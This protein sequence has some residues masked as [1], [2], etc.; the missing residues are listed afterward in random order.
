MSDIW[1]TANSATLPPQEFYGQIFTDAFY[2]ILQKGI[3]K[4]PFDADQHK[5]ERRLTCINI[6][7]QCFKRNGGTFELHREVIAEF[8]DWAGI[9]LPSLKICGIHPRDLDE[10][11]ARFEMAE[12]GRTWT[13]KTSGEERKATV[14]KFL[15][16]YPDEAA[17]RVA[18]EARYN[19]ATDE[20]EEEPLPMPEK[21]NGKGNG[22]EREVAARFL[23]ALVAQANGDVTKL[24]ELLAGNALTSRYFD[25]NSP[26][27]LELVVEA[28]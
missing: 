28:A 6:D 17:C 7:A 9:V 20:D 3:G 19:R 14:Y 16:F 8:R 12:T 4:V 23:P 27:V 11:W 25:L 13:D 5:Q 22:K 1:D 18:Y 26:E 2:C 21:G 24:S 15:E 10:R